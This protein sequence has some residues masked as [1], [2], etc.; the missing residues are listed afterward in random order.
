M[1]TWRKLLPHICE[2]KIICKSHVDV[3]PP[4]PTGQLVHVPEGRFLLLFYL[5]KLTCENLSLECR[6][7]EI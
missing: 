2:E 7:A 5:K 3:P 1:L 4:D 6:K